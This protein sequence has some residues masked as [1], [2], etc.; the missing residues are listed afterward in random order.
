MLSSKDRAYLK[1][2]AQNLN[3]AFQVGKSAITPEMTEEI[4]CYLE[5]HE[6]I[7]VNV[8]NNCGESTIEVANVLSERTKSQ[9][10]QI[11]GRKIILYK[12]SKDEPKIILPKNNKKN[13][14][15]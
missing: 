13:K 5:S 7:K 4:N 12:E 10:V 11:I 15:S 3:C 8:L 6:I 9:I 14:K 2:L 1:S